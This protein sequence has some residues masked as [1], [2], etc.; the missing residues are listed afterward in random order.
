VKVNGST[1][2]FGCKV[3]VP[4]NIFFYVPH[5]KEIHTGLEQLGGE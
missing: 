3:N 5:N 2:L 1:Q 4:Q